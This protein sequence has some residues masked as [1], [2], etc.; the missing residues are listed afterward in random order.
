MAEMKRSRLA[1]PLV[2]VLVIIAVVAIVTGFTFGPVEALCVALAGVI[3]LFIQNLFFLFRLIGWLENPVADEIPSAGR[4][5]PWRIVLRCCGM[6]VTS[7]KRT[8]SIC[9]RVKPGTARRCRH[10]LTA[11]R[12]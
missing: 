9:R 11:S 2:F 7:L 12:W 10:S 5:T 4:E 1:V 3:W 6:S 8:R